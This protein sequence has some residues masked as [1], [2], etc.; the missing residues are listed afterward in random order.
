MKGKDIINYIHRDKMPDLEEVLNSCLEA[1]QGRTLPAI[2]TSVIPGLPRD[3]L[4]ITDTDRNFKRPRRCFAKLATSLAAVFIFAIVVFT[5]WTAYERF[6]S[7]RFSAILPGRDN[8]HDA[9]PRI[10][11]DGVISIVIVPESYVDNLEESDTFSMWIY[12]Y[13]DVGGRYL[14]TFQSGLRLSQEEA[15]AINAMVLGKIFTVD[16]IPIDLFV[17]SFADVYF[18]NP[19]LLSTIIYDTY[20]RI[21]GDVTLIF[22]TEQLNS[23]NMLPMSIEITTRDEFEAMNGCRVTREDVED[24]FGVAIYFPIIDGY[25]PP[26]KHMAHHY[27][28]TPDL[29]TGECVFFKVN[30]VTIRYIC[31]A[32][33]DWSTDIIMTVARYGNNNA[34]PSN[35]VIPRKIVQEHIVAGITVFEFTHCG[36]MEFMWAHNDLLFAFFMP[37]TFEWD[38]AYEIIT[39]MIS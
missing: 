20:G 10:D 26:I 28:Y 5:V 36:G 7:G 6:E 18:T 13:V 1:S 24:F 25:E 22:P 29:L 32:I 8:P 39:R 33:P 2:R 9:Y 4:H 37:I 31:V 35:L 34:H 17:P 3:S 11:M 23:G 15:Q 27:G 12:S 21:I 38:D 14:R 19:R 16:G 30:R